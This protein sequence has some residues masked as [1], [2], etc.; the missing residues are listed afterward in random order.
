MTA[1]NK[2]TIPQ[3]VAILNSWGVEWVGTT[4]RKAPLIDTLNRFAYRHDFTC[5]DKEAEKIA[6]GLVSGLNYPLCTLVGLMHYWGQTVTSEDIADLYTF[7]HQALG[8]A[9]QKYPP[10]E[11]LPSLDKVLGLSWSKLSNYSLASLKHLCERLGYHHDYPSK[12]EML[13]YI[14]PAIARMRRR[15]ERDLVFDPEGCQYVYESKTGLQ[16][17]IT[18]DMWDNPTK[19]LYHALVLQDLKQRGFYEPDC[20]IDA[21]HGL[22]LVCDLADAPPSATS[23]KPSE[24]VRLKQGAKTYHNGGFARVSP[25]SKAIIIEQLS[26]A[27]VRI[28]SESDGIWV[29]YTVDTWD[30]ERDTYQA[31]MNEKVTL[32]QGEPNIK[33][34]PSVWFHSGDKGEVVGIVGEDS[35]RIEICLGG[36]EFYFLAKQSSLK[37]HRP[38]L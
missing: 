38:Q 32:N 29:L 4:T 24:K 1:L 10:S 37:P 12:R 19:P 36:K 8:I 16:H 30:I 33:I 3:L 6:Q 23:F 27:K 20:V 31:R 15:P 21:L 25:G 26:L 14:K 18:E 5:N 17:K 9:R 13:N 11:P 34:E 2:L 35:C 28:K 22:Y 7:H